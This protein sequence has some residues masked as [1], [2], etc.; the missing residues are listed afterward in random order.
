VTAPSLPVPPAALAGVWQ[1]VRT[2]VP[3]PIAVGAGAGFGA[4]VAAHLLAGTAM[5]DPAVLL[6]VAVA[7]IAAWMGLVAGGTSAVLA[8]ASIVLAPPPHDEAGLARAVV[9]GGALA[10]A[11]I[12]AGSQR[13]RLARLL[14]GLGDGHALARHL[15]VF[16]DALAQVRP[17]EVPNAIVERAAALVDA[18]LVA[19]TVADPRTGRHHVRAVKGANPGAVGVEVLPGVGIAGQAIRDRRT[20]LVGQAEGPGNPWRTVAA[21][22]AG[23]A[24]AGGAPAAEADVPAAA[25]R[26]APALAMPIFHSASVVATLTV[27][28]RSADRPFSADEQALLELAAPQIGLA[29]AEAALRGQL[30][31]ASLIDSVTGL[32]NRS[33]LDAALGQLLALRRRMPAAEREPLSLILFDIDGFTGLNERHGEDTGDL[34]LRAVASL[35]KQRFRES[36]VVA[37]V[38]GDGF[39]V[40]MDGADTN[41]ALAAAGEIRNQV[42]ELSLA[43]ERGTRLGLSVSAGVAMFRDEAVR[44]ETISRTVEAALDTARWSSPG[45][46]VAV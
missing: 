32:Y 18:D 41:D 31:A 28:R 38:G 39:F 23:L 27:G 8:F 4:T 9:V 25:R 24:N 26:G 1:Q 20:I 11:A 7:A 30:R 6:V 40:V 2:A 13:D 19:L 35:I 46:I 14:H 17:D 45:S 29:V 44:V 15:R 33:Y 34:V 5:I 12:I 21:R 22:V 3:L 10:A 37:R 43:D 16:G 36:D 42:R